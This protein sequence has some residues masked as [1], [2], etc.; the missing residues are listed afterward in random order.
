MYICTF[1][2]LYIKKCTCIHTNTYMYTNTSGNQKGVYICIYICTSLYLYI[3]IHTLYLIAL[4]LFFLSKEP[5]NSAPLLHSLSHLNRRKP[6]PR[7]FPITMFPD[8]EPGGRGPPSNWA[9]LVHSLSHL[10]CH[11]IFIST[12]ILMG[13]FSTERGKRDLEI[14]IIDWDLSLHQ[15]HSNCIRVSVNFVPKEP[16]NGER[17]GAGVEYHFQEI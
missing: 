2:Y 12:L 5:S 16:S 10:E 3:H 13:L 11:S 6:P 4:G 17:W 14:Y 15:R 8:H 1:P 7:G 9:P